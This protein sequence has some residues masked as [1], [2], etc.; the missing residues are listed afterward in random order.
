[1]SSAN[2]GNINTYLSLAQSRRTRGTALGRIASDMPPAL[3]L[4]LQLSDDGGSVPVSQLEWELQQKYED[5][6]A[7]GAFRDVLKKLRDSQF[8][9]VTG[10][11]LSPLAAITEKGK[12]QLALW[13]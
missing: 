4:L 13:Q 3:Q 9:E 12:G 2:I 11:V 10:D 6:F 1:M 8:V 5:T 7:G